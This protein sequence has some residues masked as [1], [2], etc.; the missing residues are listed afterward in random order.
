MTHFNKYIFYIQVT[1]RLLAG[2]G[3]GAAGGGLEEDRDLERIFISMRG[4][5]TFFDGNTAAFSIPPGML[6]AR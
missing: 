2:T 5:A 3:G 4:K 1:D 6:V